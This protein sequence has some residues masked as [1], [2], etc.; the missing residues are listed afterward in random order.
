M[1]V[2]SAA[3]HACIPCIAL[4]GVLRQQHVLKKWWALMITNAVHSGNA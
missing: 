1:H 3:A 4:R 2:M